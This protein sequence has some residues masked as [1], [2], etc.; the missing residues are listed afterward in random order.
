MGIAALHPSYGLPGDGAGRSSGSEPANH[1]FR[2]ERRMRNEGTE[3]PVVDLAAFEGCDVNAP[4]AAIDQVGMPTISI[5]YGQASAVAKSP[6]KDVYLLL[7]AIA[8]MHLKPS[9]PGNIFGP[10]AQR[11]DLRTMIPSDIRGAQSDVLEA[12]LP[13]ILH[14][15]MR[16]RVADVY[17][18]RRNG[19][20]GC[21]PG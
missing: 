7:A 11:S 4:I 10:S 14:P 5:A 2:G 13:K 15:A 18:S 16:A 21:A 1:L 19:K 12:V 17:P 9:E 20:S 8:G 3:T 6:A